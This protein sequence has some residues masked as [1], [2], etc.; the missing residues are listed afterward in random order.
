MEHTGTTPLV[1]MEEARR[2]FFP[3][4]TGPSRGTWYAWAR[5]GRLPTVRIGKRLFVSRKGMEALI[6]AGSQPGLN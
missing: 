3:A 2:E 5:Q 1:S 4:G 6:S